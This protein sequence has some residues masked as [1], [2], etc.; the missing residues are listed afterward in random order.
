MAWEIDVE[1][2][3]R[4]ENLPLSKLPRTYRAGNNIIDSVPATTLPTMQDAQIRNRLQRLQSPRDVDQDGDG[5]MTSEINLTPTSSEASEL[6]Q[7][8]TR[9]Y[10]LESA[11]LMY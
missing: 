10:Y 5:S 4:M 2:G 8:N 6:N 11:P 7:G 9:E 3:R 1:A